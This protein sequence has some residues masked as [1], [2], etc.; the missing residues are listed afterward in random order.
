MNV[1]SIQ[2]LLQRF[3]LFKDL[4]NAEIEPI[5]D[6]AKNRFYRQGTHIFMQDDPLTNVYFIHQGQIKIYRTDMQGKEQI[7]NV[8]GEGEMFPH[9]GFFRK[10]TYPAHAEVSEDAVLI[11]IP[12]HLF[13]QFLKTN[14]EICV[15][16]FRI[17][18]DKIVD[19]QNRLEEKILHNTYEQIILLLIRLVKSHGKKHDDDHYIFTTQFTNRDLANMI[20]S[21]RETVSRTL[22]SLKKSKLISSDPAGNI[23]LNMDKLKDELF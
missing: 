13:E 11:Y 5:L 6:L 17:L 23:I 14:P 4:T 19:L 3:S 7:I 2:A 8:L 18:G 20:G 10:G 1:E 22:T 9:M 12:I 21:S 16:I 15:K